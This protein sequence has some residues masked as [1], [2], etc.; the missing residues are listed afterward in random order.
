MMRRPLA[1]LAFA[2]ALCAA[3]AQGADA[4]S[5]CATPEQAK[6]VAAMYATPPAPAPFMAAPKLGMPEAVLLSALPPDQAVG[7]SGTAFL[8]VWESLQAWDR[9]L[10]LVLKAG[11]V[12]EIYGRIQP[13]EPSKVSQ[14]YNLKYPPAGLGGH[15]RPDLVAAIY[16]VSLQGREGRMR[17]IAFLDAQG[18][19]AFHV[20]LPESQEPTAAEIEQ[21]GRTRA[22]I[23]SLPRAC[24]KP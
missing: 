11:H 3:T 6:A 18:N 8:Q 24:P 16:A 15:L 7:T 21:Y 14:M 4:P 2:S 17:G 22:L 23:E 20:F 19:D 13:G 1:L 12:F 5:L 10:T 9:A